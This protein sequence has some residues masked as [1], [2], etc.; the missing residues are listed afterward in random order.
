MIE[1]ASLLIREGHPNVISHKYDATVD[2]PLVIC[3]VILIEEI[4][5]TRRMSFNLS[6]ESQ[7]YRETLFVKS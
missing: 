4:K 5:S 6:G 1:E 3:V 7:D 2:S